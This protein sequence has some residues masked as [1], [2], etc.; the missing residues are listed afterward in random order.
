ME[1]SLSAS[2][3]YGVCMTQKRIESNAKKIL[4]DKI[5]FYHDSL[6]KK[7]TYLEKQQFLL[8]DHFD[9]IKDNVLQELVSLKKT[10]DNYSC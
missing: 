6:L 1:S 10:I 7:Y 5:V 8:V 2:L 3:R 9:L 4:L